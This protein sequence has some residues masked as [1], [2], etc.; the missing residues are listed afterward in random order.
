MLGALDIVFS[1]ES[2]VFLPLD[3]LHLYVLHLYNI[4][5]FMIVDS[6]NQAQYLWT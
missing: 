6:W 4:N 1:L 2:S 5:T 3:I